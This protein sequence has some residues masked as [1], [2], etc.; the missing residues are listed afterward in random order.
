MVRGRLLRLSVAALIVVIAACSNDTAV[1]ENV[2]P[3]EAATFLGEHPAAVLLDIRTPEEFAESLIEGAVNID[4]YAADFSA[5][6]DGLDR[7]ASY[8]IYCRSGNRSNAAL[9][10]FRDLGFTAVR[11]IDGG[12][13]AW[14]QSGHPVV[15]G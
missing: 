5:R 6:L 14:Q 13:Q 11:A 2:D 9:D 1:V 10:I 12:I 7:D 4:F 15:P 8:V 3:S